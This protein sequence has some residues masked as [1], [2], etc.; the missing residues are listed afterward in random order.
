MSY[1]GVGA[2]GQACP[3][4]PQGAVQKDP[5]E[6]KYEFDIPIWG[7]SDIGVPMVQMMS[8]AFMTAERM[9]PTFVERM[10]PI[11]YPLVDQKIADAMAEVEMSIPAWT[12]EAIQAAQPEID[13]QKELVAAQ[14]ELLR[15]EALKVAAALTGIVVLS[16]GLAAWWIKTR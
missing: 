12:R 2:L 14:A 15:D 13:R 11:I 9:A 8:E 5:C 1:H 7:R 6:R 3:L 16:V 4:P 10:K